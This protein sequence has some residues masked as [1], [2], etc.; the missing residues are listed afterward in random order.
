MKK[1]NIQVEDFSYALEEALNRLRV[2]L[3]FS[4]KDTKK[5]LITSSFPNEGK[6][7]VT[8]DLWRMLAEAGIPTVLVD[9]DMRKTL[10][11]KRHHIEG[12]DKN[13]DIGCYL[14]G[15]AEY[16]DV[17]YETNIE[18]AYCVPCVNTVENPSVLLEDGRLKELLDRLS[19]EYRYVLVD[20]PPLDSVADGSV[21][22]SLCDGV[23]SGWQKQEKIP[24][25]FISESLSQLDSAECRVLGMVLNKV[26]LEN[27]PYKKYYGKYKS[28][29]IS[30][31]MNQ[32][33]KKQ[34]ASGQI[35][36]F[37]PVRL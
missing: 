23:T 18:N 2:N 13:K 12:V 34:K 4:G 24:K 15:I 7:R 20:T 22:A 5:I 1:I 25:K 14:T 6:S 28:M 32:D 26:Q 9:A 27:I 31:S 37:T 29:D 35:S 8:V 33:E 36:I 3:K 17:V 10:L 16:E 19:M 30:I 11:K 21:I